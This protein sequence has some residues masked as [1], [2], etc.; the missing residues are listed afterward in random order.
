MKTIYFYKKQI[1]CSVFLF[2][3]YTLGM[4]NKALMETTKPSQKIVILVHGL[5]RTPAS[6]FFLRTYLKKQGY[7]VYS[8]D[9]PSAKNTI[10]EHGLSLNRYLKKVLIEHPHTKIY[11]VTHSL[12]GIIARDALAQLPKKDLNQIGGLVMLAPPN[13]GS[14]LA[15]LSL[16]CFPMMSYFVKPMTE[17]SS[18]QNAY[19]HQVPVPKVKIAIIAGRYDAKVPPQYARLNG[20]AAPFIVNSTHTFIMNNKEAKLYI[21]QFIDN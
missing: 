21:K 3:F 15:K 11:L 4:A 2:F 16:K 9:Y 1:I 18:D 19:V 17:L 6:M 12:G 5:M 7:Q 8:Y 14:A 20:E 10:H 13:Q